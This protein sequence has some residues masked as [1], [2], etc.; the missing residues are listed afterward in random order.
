[1]PPPGRSAWLATLQSPAIDLH[2]LARADPH[3]NSAGIS[4]APAVVWTIGVPRSRARRHG[5]AHDRI[6]RPA[7][8]RPTAKA[9]TQ[10]S[11]RSGTRYGA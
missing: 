4:S 7:R 6:R 9:T 10:W 8:A 1:M 5:I 11:R 3:R 2:Y